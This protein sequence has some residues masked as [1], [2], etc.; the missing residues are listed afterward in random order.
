M[1]C[2]GTEW[3]VQ[4]YNSKQCQPPGTDPGQGQSP[5]PFP[6]D[7]DKYYLYIGLGIVAAF[8]LGA[9]LSR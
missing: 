5:W 1:R 6:I 7:D 9:L 2:N 8:G 4:E 3:L